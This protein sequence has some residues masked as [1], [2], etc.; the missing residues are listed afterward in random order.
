MSAEPSGS[1]QPEVTPEVEEDWAWLAIAPSRVD[2]RSDL[3]VVSS[4]S[5]GAIPTDAAY[6]SATR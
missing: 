6:C 1:W 4:A 3:A 2:S 5:V